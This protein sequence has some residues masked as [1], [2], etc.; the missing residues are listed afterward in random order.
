MGNTEVFREM[1]LRK[2]IKKIAAIGTGLTFLGATAAMSVVAADLA[3]YPKP[4]VQD[5]KF[6]GV[7]VIGDKAAAEDVIGVSDIAVS[8]QFAATTSVGVTSDETVTVAGDAIKI[9]RSGEQ[10]AIG[11]YIQNVTESLTASDSDSLASYEVS[12]NKGTTDVNQYLRFR[13]STG[14]LGTDSVGKITYTNNDDDEVGDFL[15]FSDGGLAFQYEI[16]FEEGFK[17][18]TTAG[19]ASNLDDLE[20][21]TLTILGK[22]YQVTRATQSA[23]TAAAH[24]TITLEMMGGALSDVLSEGEEKVYTIDGKDYTVKNTIITDTGTIYGKFVIN[25]FATKKLAEGETEK[26]PDGTIFGIND[27]LPNEAGDITGDLVEIYLGANRIVLKDAN[28]SATS[29]DGTVEVNEETIEDAEVNFDWTNTSSEFVLNKISYELKADGKSGNEPYI[30]SGEGLRQY[31]DEPQG[32][33]GG[34]EDGWDITYEGLTTPGV[35]KI[36]L[37]PSGDDEYR[38][39]FTNTNGIEY[40]GV[41]LFYGSGSTVYY[42]DTTSALIF[43]QEPTGSGVTSVN[44]SAYTIQKDDYFVVSH[45]GNSDTGV[46]N[47]LKFESLDTS[48][49]E[50]QL[51]DVAGGEIKSTYSGTE[52]TLG[53]AIGTFNVGGYTYDYAVHYN[54]TA[55]GDAMSRLYI[56]L[57]DSGA[58]GGESFITVQGGGWLDLGTQNENSSALIPRQAVDSNVTIN[59]AS[60]NFETTAASNEVITF[61]VTSASSEVDVSNP[62]G[63]GIS[64]K[65]P[66]DD[67]DLKFGMSNYGVYIYA[68]TETNDP[69]TLNIEYPL[70]QKIGQAFVTFGAITKSAGTSGEAVE[71][72][73][74]QKIEVGA[75]KLAS[76]ISNVFGQNAILVGGPC[77]NLAAATAL[78]N[79]ADCTAGFEAGKGII[80]VVEKSGKVAMIVAGYSAKD[81]RTA[82][83]VVA[84]YK[85]YAGELT[86]QKVE[87]TTATSSVREVE[88]TEAAMEEAAE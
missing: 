68:K 7:L 50:V 26:L 2:A 10:L 73:T 62:S 75:T 35:S 36:D 51:S 40:R 77:A 31:L 85:D 86:G 27:I 78:G 66:E 25:G 22:E 46:S 83:S 56:D 87:V 5:G 42:G 65:S 63:G 47:V 41:R 33:L 55:T 45:N 6:S 34:S 13:W 12:N 30:K 79:P 52:T 37:T 44:T 28:P 71:A 38:L 88:V 4:F 70:R 29:T 43:M 18:T 24:S 67:N 60:D 59:T 57:D 8:L 76:E 61:A 58:L 17:A 84:N 39:A 16:E 23:G 49:N 32:M 15:Y 81:T 54:S 14:M 74:I 80:Q 69:D 3:D 48:N 53:D 82:A 11:E 72:V 9:E 19:T 64:L 1:K 20:D 21:E